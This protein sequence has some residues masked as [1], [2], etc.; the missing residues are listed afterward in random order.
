M[1][2]DPPDR[3]F[4]D[5]LGKPRKT[6]RH[7]NGLPEVRGAGDHRVSPRGCLGIGGQNLGQGL[8]RGELEFVGVRLVSLSPR[9]AAAEG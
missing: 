2:Q 9:T 4:P 8:V 7:R 3:P 6:S 5:L 1:E